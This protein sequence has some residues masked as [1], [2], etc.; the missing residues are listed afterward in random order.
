MRDTTLT[1]PGVEGRDVTGRT[2]AGN[3]ECSRPMVE[4]S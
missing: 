4:S 2:L 3:T 1:L